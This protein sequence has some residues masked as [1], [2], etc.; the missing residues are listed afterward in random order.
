MPGTSRPLTARFEPF[1]SP[2]IDTDRLLAGIRDWVTIESPSA[3]GQA[4]NR[5]VDRVAADFAMAGATVTR[6]A[7]Q[8]GFGDI[9]EARSPWG[10][11]GPGILV[12]GHLDTV[13][14]IGTIDTLPIERRGD[15]MFGPGI[16]D[17]KSGVYLAFDALRRLIAAGQS[18]PLPIRFLLVPDEEVG[19]PTSRAR[20]EAAARA[21]KF[22]L[23][24]EPGRDGGKV[25]TGRK[26]WG[27]F[28][29]TAIGRAAHAGA[30]RR[31]GRSAIREMSR[32]VLALEDM[33]DEA[34]GVTVTVGT[35]AGGTAPNTVAAECRASIDLRVPDP[36]SADEMCARILGLQ[37]HDPDVTLRMVGGLNRPPFIKSPATA[38]L[39]ARARDLAAELGI[40][41]QDLSSVGG[42]SDA[43][44]TAALGVPT[45]DGLGPDGEGAH[46]DHEHIH[47]SSLAPRAALLRRLFE[48]LS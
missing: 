39:F 10:G 33:S 2:E 16:Y 32:Q 19:S 24:T 25:V 43:N 26:G 30:Q 1:G 29:L 23:V 41:L 37:P 46:S 44:F 9:L 45:L 5:L 36:D 4:V 47:V 38:A 11:T 28:E 13:H 34:R 40:D 21:A 22:V 14:P 8:G 48:T 6:I 17:M 20:I 7:G 31:D 42:A 27:R 12:L 35:I 15:D 18:T 3:N